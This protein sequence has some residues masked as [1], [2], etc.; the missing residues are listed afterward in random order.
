[1]IGV[2]VWF[3]ALI[4]IVGGVVAYLGDSIGRNIGKKRLKVWRL[5]PK[6][7]AALGTF[8]AGMLGT[9]ATIL[10][11]FALAE[12]VRV[13][14]LEG[15]AAR[16][17]LAIAKKDLEKTSTELQ[18]ARDQ[19]ANLQ[20]QLEGSNAAFEEAQKNLKSTQAE[21]QEARDTNQRLTVETRSLLQRA[22]AFQNQVKAIRG[23]L[24][25][26]R[27]EK[28]RLLQEIE[29]GTATLGK[30]SNDNSSLVTENLRLVDEG[31]QLEKQLT[32]QQKKFDELTGRYDVLDKA[33]EEANA[34]FDT[35]LETNRQ[36]LETAQ[37]ELDATLRNLRSE[38]AKLSALES[39][40]ALVESKAGAARTTPLIVGVRDELAR[41]TLREQANLAEARAA[42]FSLLNRAKKDAEARGAGK[43]FEGEYAGLLRDERNSLSPDEQAEALAQR[44]VGL[45]QRVALV[46]WSLANAFAEE[47][48]PL[49][50]DVFE[51]PVVY[52]AD[53]QVLA[54]QVDGRQSDV[55]VADA[56]V[57]EVANRLTPKA[58]ADGMIPSRGRSAP[59]GEL[60]V[61]QIEEIVRRVREVRR[62]IRVILVA[63]ED[64]RA[65]DRIKLDF[66]LR[67]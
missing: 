37:K 49:R 10:L 57:R 40:A 8:F 25:P 58:V 53:Q 56:V 64:T 34:S 12:P 47:F 48:V 42:V 2:S 4:V 65:S 22:D 35:Q 51:D 9:L 52:R 14:I 15:E 36:A 43:S 33:F 29:R 38:Q 61:Q 62:P 32:A 11:L 45:P 23:E 59:L 17:Q 6:H 44:L 20:A 13:W 30:I 50:I 26:L 19:R 39:Y 55:L 7:T 27:T 5:R 16:D 54:I 31:Q 67:P 46:A 18:T 63:A 60:S 21:A 24:T 1:M 41:V 28:N 66:R 3:L